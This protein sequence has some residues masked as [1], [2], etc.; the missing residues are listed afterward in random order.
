METIFRETDLAEATGE[1]EKIG[2]IYREAMR[3]KGAEMVAFKKIAKRYYAWGKK[4]DKGQTTVRDI[5][6]SFEQKHKEPTGDV[7]SIGAYRG[8]LGEL[9]SMV[10]E[11]GMATQEHSLER[12]EAKL[13]ALQEKLGKEQSKSAAR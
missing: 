10:K 1:A 13:K 3:D 8:A 12:R 9:I 7:F 11:Q 6:S 2:R 5:L 4:N